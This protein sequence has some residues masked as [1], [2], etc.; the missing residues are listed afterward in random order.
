MI[1][2][3][4]VWLGEVMA[5]VSF[6]RFYIGIHHGWENGF[7]VLSHV[8]LFEEME[9][10]KGRQYA[11]LP[12]HGFF[13]GSKCT[14]KGNLLMDKLLDSNEDSEVITKFFEM[15][16]KTR[17]ARSGLVNPNASPILQR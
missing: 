9:S 12:D 13:S 3:E 15:R 10:Q 8:M 4:K 6:R 17:S 1:T 14:F 7:P 2:T 16:D 5:T 11:M